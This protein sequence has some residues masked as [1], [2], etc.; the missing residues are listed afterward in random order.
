VAIDTHLPRRCG[1]RPLAKVFTVDSDP[2]R[3]IVTLV[4]LVILVW[5]L[6]ALSLMAIWKENLD[7]L[8]EGIIWFSLGIIGFS[9]VIVVLSVYV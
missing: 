6:V 4:P 8:P 7:Q 2:F 5:S 9:S 3:M 1:G